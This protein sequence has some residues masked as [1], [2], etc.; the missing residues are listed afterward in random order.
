MT[1][2]R[3]ASARPAGSGPRG[4]TRSPRRLAAGAGGPGDIDEIV[5]VASAIKGRTFCPLG[6]A[7]ALP[8]LALVGKFRAELEERAAEAAA[9]K[10]SC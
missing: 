10:A 6:D 5:R 1:T 4:C 3:A 8:V 2:N 9:R 7:A